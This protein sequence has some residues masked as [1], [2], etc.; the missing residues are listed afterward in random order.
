MLSFQILSPFA[1]LMAG[2]F[3]ALSPLL[4]EA[5]HQGPSLPRQV[6]G[7]LHGRGASPGRPPLPA[8][9]HPP[10]SPPGWCHTHM[11]RAWS[12]PSLKRGPQLPCPGL[13]TTSETFPEPVQRTG[14][15]P[16]ASAIA[17]FTEGF[18]RQLPLGLCCFIQGGE[19]GAEQ[20]RP[21]RAGTGG[22]VLGNRWASP[23]RGGVRFPASQS[24]S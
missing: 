24:G 18:W 3:M 6:P 16:V 21:R 12:P 4:Q 19:L 1:M 17:R 2:K 9:G 20:M 7:A 10:F 15:L 5:S 13:F 8:P 14:L 11:P 22:L 23:A